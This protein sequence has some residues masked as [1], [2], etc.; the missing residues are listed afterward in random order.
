MVMNTFRK[1]VAMLQNLRRAIFGVPASDLEASR[2]AE[3]RQQAES[4]PQ[5][6]PE[7]KLTE[8]QIHGVGD[9]G[10]VWEPWRISGGEQGEQWY[11][12][13]SGDSPAAEIHG[14]ATWDESPSDDDDDFG[15]DDNE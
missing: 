2:M 15:G 9:A 11:R 4:E 5:Y 1:V 8:R 6:L 3:V 13:V 14:E 12:R 10:D 7:S